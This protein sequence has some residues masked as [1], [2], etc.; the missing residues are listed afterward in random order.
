MFK[1]LLFVA[2]L[3]VGLIS[4]QASAAFVATDWKV[5]GDRLATL[6]TVTGIEWL[7]L[8]ESKGMS[9]SLAKQ[10]IGD[11]GKFQGWRLP[12]SVEVESLFSRVFTTWGDIFNDDGTPQDK[13][14][15]N[16]LTDSESI[17]FATLFGLSGRVNNS[18][19]FAE[20]SFGLYANSLSETLTA[21]R[22][23]QYYYTNKQN[24]ES[25]HVGIKRVDESF[26][27]NEYSVFLV[28][29]G[30]TTLSSINDPTLN[31]NNPNAPIHMADVP[32]PAG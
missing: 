30:G 6:D 10:A 5:S 4:T 17:L 9:I 26:S 28:S 29:D 2:T 31:I 7:D 25:V 3:V 14:T 15:T 19:N 32:V 11:G 21:G 1:K 24:R 12:T 23:R 18:T 8:T 27:I 13:I 20:W 22:F 16:G